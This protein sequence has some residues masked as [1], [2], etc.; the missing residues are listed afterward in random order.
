M[1]NFFLLLFSIALIAG[2][3]KD[4]LVTDVLETRGKKPKNPK[5]D[6]VQ[7]CH[8]KKDG[9]YD[10]KNVKMKDVQKEIEKGSYVL[11]ADGDG[12]TAVGACSGSMDDCD[13]NDP[14]AN[15]V[16]GCEASCPC[17]DEVD[18]TCGSALCAYDDGSYLSMECS[19]TYLTSV[20]NIEGTYYVDFFD[21]ATSTNCS[22]ENI[23][24]AEYKAC[25]TLLL[26]VAEGHYECGG[27]SLRIKAKEL[28]KSVQKKGSRLKSN[29]IERE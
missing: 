8:L 3:S 4:P 9:S 24:E 21:F 5:K 14:D 10:V 22:Y 11:D 27:E 18:L 1:K 19:G 13:D 7:M 20:S 23:T 17:F 6:E 16:D 25:R 15:P 12:F 2:C 29:K 26:P 28:Q